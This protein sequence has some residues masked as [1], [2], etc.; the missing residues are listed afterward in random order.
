MIAMSG[1]QRIHLRANKRSVLRI[2]SSNVHERRACPD[3][4]SIQRT[5]LM[6]GAARA[7]APRSRA[8]CSIARA[9]RWVSA[10]QPLRFRSAV[11]LTRRRAIA[12]DGE[13]G[14]VADDEGN[15]RIAP[16]GDVV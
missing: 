6:Q 8:P 5:L 7:C 9:K 15:G 12:E 2:V 13:S 16:S 10:A 3:L 4:V 11:T 14:G 1:A